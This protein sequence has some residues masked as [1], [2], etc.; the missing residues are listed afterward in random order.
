M[1]FLMEIE[2]QSAAHVD[3]HAHTLTDSWTQTDLLRLLFERRWW[4]G[5]GR[6]QAS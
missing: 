4:F 3:A 2:G 6:R 1:V 5:A